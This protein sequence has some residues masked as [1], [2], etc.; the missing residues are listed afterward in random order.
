MS[1]IEITGAEYEEQV[2]RSPLPVMVDFYAEWCGP[3]RLLAPVL[4]E[5]AKELNGSVAVFKVDAMENIELMKVSAS[6]PCRP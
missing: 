5:V 3:C 2:L 1:V 6:P 4:E